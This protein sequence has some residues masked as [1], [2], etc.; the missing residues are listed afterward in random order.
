MSTRRYSN[1]DE[2]LFG[3]RTKSI[4]QLNGARKKSKAAVPVTS[5]SIVL[6]QGQ[7]D[8]IVLR[9]KLKSAAQLAKSSLPS[10]VWA[11]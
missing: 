4:S 7:L 11:V 6:T 3:E 5:N 2:S 9:S 10:E 8:S 1:V